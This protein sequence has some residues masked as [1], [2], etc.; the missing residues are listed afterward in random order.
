MQDDI[1]H[2]ERVLVKLIMK[3]NQRKKQRLEKK[4]TDSNT[5]QKWNAGSHD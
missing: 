3:A 1:E 5:N 2:R 4:E